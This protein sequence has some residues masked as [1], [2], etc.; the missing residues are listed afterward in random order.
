MLGTPIDGKT[1]MF[2]D[3]QRVSSPALPFFLIPL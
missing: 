2:G 1:Y 3:N